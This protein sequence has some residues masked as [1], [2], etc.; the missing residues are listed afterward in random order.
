MK[1]IDELIQQLIDN[2]TEQVNQHQQL[3]S[4]LTLEEENLGDW[5][6]SI[7]LKNHSEKLRTS[8]KLGELESAR[9]L[10]IKDLAEL[11]NL[12]SDNLKLKEV[13]GRCETEQSQQLGDLHK[14]LL[15]TVELIQSTAQSIQ[16]NSNARLIPIEQSLKLLTAVNKP[17]Q[18]YSQQGSLKGTTK[19]KR[20]QV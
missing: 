6:G 9:Q 7:L 13:I 14:E 16:Q 8:S 19:V 10:V 3:L 2:L 11:W 1:T 18:T 15:A 20:T 12:S 4:Q 5:S 17:Q